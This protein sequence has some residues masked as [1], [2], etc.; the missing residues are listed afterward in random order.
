MKLY[1]KRFSRSSSRKQRIIDC[2]KLLLDSFQ[3]RSNLQV[4][5]RVDESFNCFTRLIVI[6]VQ[7]QIIRGAHGTCPK[8]VLPRLV[9]VCAI[10][11]RFSAYFARNYCPSHGVRIRYEL[12]LYASSAQTR[13]KRTSSVRGQLQTMAFICV[14][15]TISVLF[16]TIHKML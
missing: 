4:R 5:E 9:V 14:N 12:K 11:N 13:T 1:C 6:V 15:R 3:K 8:H 10:S 7:T 16:Q 2:K